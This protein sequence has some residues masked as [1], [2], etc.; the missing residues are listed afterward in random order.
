MFNLICFVIFDMLEVRRE[1]IFLVFVLLKNLIFCFI[2]ELNK[3]L[4]IF[5]ENFVVIREKKLFRK[6]VVIAVFSEISVMIRIEVIN[7]VLFFLIVM[8]F[9]IFLV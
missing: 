5:L 3:K 8:L 9:I 2:I 1:I 7:L 4:L 6:L